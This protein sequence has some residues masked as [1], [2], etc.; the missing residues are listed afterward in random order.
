MQVQRPL[1]CDRIHTPLA[2][3]AAA[4]T[5]AE[6]AAPRIAPRTLATIGIAAGVVGAGIGISYLVSHADPDGAFMRWM[7][8]MV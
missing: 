5:Q 4:T 8:G 1:A 6:H 2:P 3:L 7:G